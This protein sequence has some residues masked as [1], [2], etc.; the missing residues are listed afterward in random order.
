[1]GPHPPPNLGIFE[2]AAFFS[3]WVGPSRIGV[4]GYTARHTPRTN[5]LRGESIY[6]EGGLWGVESILSIIGTRGP[7][8]HT[9]IHTHRPERRGW[10]SPFNYSQHK[11]FHFSHVL[12][13]TAPRVAV[14]E[15]RGRAR[16]P[17]TLN[18][19]S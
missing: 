7:V 2:W 9:H 13:V 5:R 10:V 11:A 18:P 8:T 19:K 12:A 16:E 6:L 4:L 3:D 15:C 17:V 14:H 1:M